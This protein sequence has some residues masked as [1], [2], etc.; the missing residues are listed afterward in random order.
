MMEG[1]EE[2]SATESGANLQ[3]QS[4]ADPDPTSTQDITTHG[5]HAPLTM[6][7][8]GISPPP[9]T[10]SAQTPPTGKVRQRIRKP[11]KQ[12]KNYPIDLSL[13]VLNVE[14]FILMNRLF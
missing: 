2:T 13:L 3:L 5:A 12:R 8:A 7:Q 14:L 9:H 10:N 6:T 1:E 4:T 11:R